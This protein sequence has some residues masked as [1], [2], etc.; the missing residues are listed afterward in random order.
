MRDIIKNKQSLIQ[1]QSQN[2]NSYFIRLLN[3]NE[4][5]QFLNLEMKIEG[6]ENYLCFCFDIPFE[7]T[8]ENQEI[9]SNVLVS[10]YKRGSS[11]SE[12]NQESLPSNRLVTED[13]SSQSKRPSFL[14]SIDEGLFTK[15]QS[16]NS[17]TDSIRESVDVID[18]FFKIRGNTLSKFKINNKEM[19]RLHSSRLLSKGLRRFSNISML[20]NITFILILIN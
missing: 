6:S 4:V 3:A 13:G 10:N 12:V 2:F 5:E 7:I 14:T 17:V 16:F 11:S 1:I 19:P 9:S 8:D 20:F 15:R 18:D